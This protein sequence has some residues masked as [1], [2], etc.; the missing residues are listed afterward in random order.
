MTRRISDIRVTK[1]ILQQCMNCW[2]S[3]TMSQPVNFDVALLLHFFCIDPFVQGVKNVKAL[4]IV[5]MVLQQQLVKNL[6][7]QPS[8]YC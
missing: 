4:I 6:Y 7:D 8:E 2:L 3:Y 5:C 1:S